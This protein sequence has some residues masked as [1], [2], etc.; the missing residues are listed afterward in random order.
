MRYNSRLAFRAPRRVKE[1]SFMRW[2]KPVFKVVA[3]TFEVT[4]YM[5]K[6]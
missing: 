6:R 4:A 5:G 3:A 1:D 2:I